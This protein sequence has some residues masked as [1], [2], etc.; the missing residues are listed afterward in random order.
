MTRLRRKLRSRLALAAGTAAV[1]LASAAPAPA[2]AAGA[3]LHRE[4]GNLVFDN[5][6]PPDAALAARL[7][8][9]LESRGARLLDWLPDGSV[10]IATRFGDTEQ[11]HRVAAPMGAREQ[12]TFYADPVTAA[13]AA[14]SG[15]GL[16]FL[17]D[18]DG[19][20]NAQLY[21]RAAD[22]AVRQLTSGKFIHGSPVWAHD[23]RRVAFCGNDRDGLSVDVYLADVGAHTAAQLLVGGGKTDTRADTWYPLD[24]STDDAKLLVERYVSASESYLY[25]ADVASGALTP[26]DPHAGKAGIHAAKF[27]PDG[28]GVYELSDEAGEFTQVLYR[29]LVTHE[30][31]RLT[32]DDAG[33]DV[34][35]FDLSADGRY[36]AYVQ[37]QDGRSHLVLEDTTSRIETSPAGIPEGVISGL[38]F[39]HSGDRVALSVETAQSPRDVYVY[40]LRHDKLER[41]TKSELGPIAERDLV[42]P[43][44]V[45]FPTWDRVAGHQRML[46]AYLYR[47]RSASGPCPVV[48]LIHGGPE[49]QFR[50]GWEPFVEFLANELG[51]AVVAPNVRGSSGYGKS[52]L[53]LDGGELQ[54]D[55]VR[56]IGSLLV[57]L[58]VQTG[59]DREHV[60][61]MGA[62]SGGY[63]ALASLVTYGERLSGA[64][65]AFPDHISPLTNV[66]RIRK[67]LLVVAGLND[68]R[69]PA[70]ESDQLVWQVRSG[71]GEVWYLAAKDEGHGF[72][73]KADR[74]AYLGTA[75][76]FLQKLAR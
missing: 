40:D 20:E 58:G 70:S 19:D 47:P 28:H 71:G 44:L 6:P 61:V 24:W 75:A 73:K 12:L 26:V 29:D 72:G 74:D 15:G 11:L 64:I 46:S 3:P 69:V 60:A 30:T 62:S 66:G 31:R 18:Q 52:F 39:D 32:P 59:F 5:I 37:N 17:K 65:G 43:E 55:A 53:A 50:P 45:R 14:P 27:S 63:V 8:R 35:E 16:V 4:S 23:G 67:P 56:D 49:A 42:T 36:L 7:S 76:M 41:W 9:Y 21:Y 10:L 33:W 13:R 48:V 51:Y 57:W 2:P 38:R 1:L 25:V 34:E 54:E 22:G 68:P